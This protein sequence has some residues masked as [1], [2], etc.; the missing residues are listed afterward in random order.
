MDT[1]DR[2][3]ENGGHPRYGEH[4]ILYQFNSLGYRCPEFERSAELRVVAV[5]CS[6]VMGVGLPRGAL[7]HDRFAA[8]LQAQTGRSSVVWTL[9][10]AGASNDYVSRILQLAVPVL[11][12]DVVLVN[13]TQ[14]A[15]REYVSVE[16]KVIRYNPGWHPSDPI[17]REIKSHFDALSSPYDDQFNL[18][19]NYQAID[20][21]LSN[22]HWLFSTSDPEG[23]EGIMDHVDVRRFAGA[24]T[25]LDNARDHLHPGAESH[26]DLA[27]R[28]WERYLVLSGGSERLGAP[29]VAHSTLDSVTSIRASGAGPSQLVPSGSTA[30]FV[31]LAR[32]LGGLF[33]YV[34]HR[35]RRRARLQKARRD[36]PNIYPLW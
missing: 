33:R 2:F 24:L 17:D 21:L 30:P 11:D 14:S 8:R 35:L 18:F 10:C 7:F 36:D 31:W 3:R 34:A 6:N 26:A 23:L 13:F 22:R 29:G 5:G 25:V 4:D 15:R 27:A 16:R 19:K 12:P 32:K 20:R 9:G 1:L 28:Y